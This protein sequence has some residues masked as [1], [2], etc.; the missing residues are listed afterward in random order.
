MSQNSQREQTKTPL[1]NELVNNEN[2][3]PV[4][5][6]ELPSGVKVFNMCLHARHA[7]WVHR[8]KQFEMYSVQANQGAGKSSLGVKISHDFFGGDWNKVAQHLTFELKPIIPTLQKYLDE[9]RVMPLLTFDDAALPFSKYM[10]FQKGGFSHIDKINKFITLSRTI[11]SN[12][13]MISVSDDLLTEVRN[14]SWVR[15]LIHN[16]GM[17]GNIPL[18]NDE[19]LALSYKVRVVPD[20]KR[21]YPKMYADIYPLMYGYAPEW[22]LKWYRE[23]RKKATQKVLTALMESLMDDT[24]YAPTPDEVVAHECWI[25]AGKSMTKG[26]VAA[27]ERGVYL[28]D[29]EFKKAVLQVEAWEVRK[30][31]AEMALKGEEAG[32][33]GSKD[34]KD[35][36]NKGVNVGEELDLLK[37]DDY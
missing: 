9:D 23:E 30:R 29:S 18:K 22:F 11:C 31:K 4:K 26:V 6:V 13:I 12:I 20:G 37:E 21:Y 33:S 10:Q 35:R 14:K 32:L 3:E 25:N 2:S 5:M 36:E 28:D 15:V 24:G 34:E 27:S 1:M 17:F 7:Q 19:R 8:N 16:V